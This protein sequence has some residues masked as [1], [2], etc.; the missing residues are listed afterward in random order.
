MKIDE[1]TWEELQKI[2]LDQRTYGFT[3]KLKALN[4][5]ELDDAVIHSEVKQS[6]QAPYRMFTDEPW[7]DRV[8]KARIY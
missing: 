1:M 7:A 3:G 6:D 5:S 8:D 2:C 4:K